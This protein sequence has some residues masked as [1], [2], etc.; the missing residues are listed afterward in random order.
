M[1]NPFWGFQ[2]IFFPVENA[3]KKRKSPLHQAPWEGLNTLPHVFAACFRHISASLGPADH[4]WYV[5][6]TTW[7][8][9]CARSGYLLT[10]SQNPIAQR[11]GFGMIRSRSTSSPFEL[12]N[13]GLKQPRRRRQQKPHKF[14]HLT[15][16][17][18]F[19]H[20]LHV[21][22]SF[23]DIFLDVLVLS[24]TWNDLFCSCVG[25]VSVWWQT[26]NFVLFPERWFLF[27]SRIVRTHFSS[28]M[29]LN[30]WKMIAETRSHIFRWRSRFRRRQLLRLFYVD[31]VVPN[32]RT[33]LSLA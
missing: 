30:N 21:H 25:N 1:D 8:L 28:I 12:N 29:T 33:A 16:K 6:F 20:A 27:N 19:L 5:K 13:R 10:L 14:A 24:T 4:L 11:A 18:V 7:D 3:L 9:T 2:G 31:H 15:I 23:F 17:T 32:T 26:F 22:F